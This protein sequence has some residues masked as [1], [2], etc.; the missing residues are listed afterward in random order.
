MFEIRQAFLFLI[1]LN[2]N[3]FNVN[4]EPKY[5]TP[6]IIASMWNL[7]PNCPAP[8]F[9]LIYYEWL[10]GVECRGFIRLEH[11]I[12]DID[13]V[14]YPLENDDILIDSLGRVF[15]LKFDEFVFPNSVIATWSE[16]E[17][18]QNIIPALNYN[19]NAEFEKQ[20]LNE[21]N[22]ADIISKM[23]TFFTW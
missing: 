21:K 13:F 2:S 22:V 16:D 5:T 12:G 15:D 3:T 6:D 4:M 14:G 11:L 23:A 1:V 17:L 20:V 7:P 19:G 10:K 18:K 9:P 8:V